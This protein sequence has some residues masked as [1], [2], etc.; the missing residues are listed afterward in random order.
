VWTV[1]SAD[2]ALP[3]AVLAL[4]AMRKAG[5]DLEMHIYYGMP[6]DFM[7]FPELEIMH[8]GND[9]AMKWLLRAV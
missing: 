8:K 6:H 5:K 3:P 1:G 9:E 4:D 2:Q 7:K